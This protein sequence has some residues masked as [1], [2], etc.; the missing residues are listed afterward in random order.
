MKKIFLSMFLAF[1]MSFIVE[2]IHAQNEDILYTETASRLRGNNERT[3]SESFSVSSCDW[4]N[5]SRFYFSFVSTSPRIYLNKRDGSDFGGRIGV[6]QAQVL[7][8]SLPLFFCVGVDGTVVFYKDGSNSETLAHIAMPLQFSG[9]IGNPRFSIEPFIGFHGKANLVG[10]QSYKGEAINCFSAEDM[11]SQNK[12]S[13]FQLGFQT[14][15]G[16]NFGQSYL[17]YEYRV[18]LTPLQRISEL[19]F[20]THLISL[21]YNF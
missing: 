8:E 21:G 5:Y 3:R 13:R 20:R 19:K 7:F 6:S 4:N 14:G 1:T 17:G 16:I 2:N 12:Y 10:K 18:D 15:L 9:K 11:G